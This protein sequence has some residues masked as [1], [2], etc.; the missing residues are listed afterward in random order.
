V[1]DTYRR[2]SVKKLIIVS[3]LAL[4]ALTPLAAAGLAGSASPSAG[5]S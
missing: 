3:M 1:T 2:S 4:A 5:T